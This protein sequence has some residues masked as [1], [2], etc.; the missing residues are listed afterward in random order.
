MTF[1]GLPCELLAQLRIL[2]RDAHRAGVQVALAHHDAAHR[3]QRRGGEPEF[4]GAQQRG[5]GHVAAGLELAVGLH[6]DAAAQI[7]QHQ[8]LLRFRQSQFPGNARVL[9][10]GERRSA[11]AAVVSADQNHVGVGL[12][13]A[14]GHRS[15]ARFGHQLDRNARLGIDVLQVVDQL[16]QIFDRIDIVVRR[17][18]NQSHAGNRVPHPRDDFV[19]LVAGKLA[20]LAGLRALRDLDL[21]IVGVDQVVGGD[22]EAPRSHLFDG[23]AAPVAVG[24]RAGSALHPRRPRRYSSARRCGSWRWPAFRALLC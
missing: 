22:A 14:R 10:G 23:A 20:A 4:L 1:S 16:R 18:R 6:D 21:Q 24:D 15:H 5:D 17:R 8:H 3:D 2:R 19:H 7:V 12:G 11:R 9:D 13:H